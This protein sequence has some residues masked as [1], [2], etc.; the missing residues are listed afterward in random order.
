MEI[1][2]TKPNNQ[3]DTLI[4]WFIMAIYLYIV[5]MYSENTININ[6]NYDLIG[7]KVYNENEFGFPVKCER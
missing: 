3:T 4:I 5:P 7:T 1:Q 6:T 2:K